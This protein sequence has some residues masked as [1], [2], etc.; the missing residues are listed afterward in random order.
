M[1]IRI[2][3]L[4]TFYVVARKGAMHQAARELGVT[5][6]AISQRMRAVEDRCGKRLFSRS[7][8]GIELTL[9]GEKLWTDIETA[10]L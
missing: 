6:G 5:P 4:Y 10:F 3:D 9:S 1:T 8:N 2:Q 7:R